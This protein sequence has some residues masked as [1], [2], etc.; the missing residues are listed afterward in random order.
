MEK[1]HTPSKQGGFNM[2]ELMFTLVIIGILAAGIFSVIGGRVDA[3]KAKSYGEELIQSSMNLIER[4]ATQPAGDRYTGLTL[5]NSTVALTENIRNSVNAGGTQVDLEWGA[6]A[7]LTT[8][9][10][11]GAAGT[12]NF[13]WTIAGLPRA[14]CESM[15]KAMAPSAQVILGGA[16]GTTVVRSRMMNNA[17]E[18]ADIDSTCA[19]DAATNTFTAVY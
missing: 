14:Q 19:N 6:S 2:V 7:T 12:T 5:A 17:L 10:P 13:K 16:G 8:S 4:H 9:D 3:T 15:L 11:N 1:I 18:P